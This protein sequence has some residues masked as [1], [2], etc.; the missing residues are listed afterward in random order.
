MAIVEVKQVP[1][2]KRSGSTTL[3]MLARLCFYYPQ[4]TFNQARTMPAKRVNLL[5]EEAYR[6]EA[7][8][9]AQLVQI[10]AAP[11]TDKGK[12]VKKLTNHYQRIVDG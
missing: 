3:R 12:G 9:M 4:F 7:E 11:H 8:R 6:I 2:T 10:A 5:L 1:K